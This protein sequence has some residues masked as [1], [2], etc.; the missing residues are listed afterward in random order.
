MKIADLICA[1]SLF[2]VLVSILAWITFSNWF[3]FCFLFFLV[4]FLLS[5]GNLIAKSEQVR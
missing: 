1:V 3:L 2:G 4:T 5:A